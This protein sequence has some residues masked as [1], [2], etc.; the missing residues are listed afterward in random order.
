MFITLPLQRPFVG[1]SSTSPQWLQLLKFSALRL[2]LDTLWVEA[3][4]LCGPFRFVLLF[5]HSGAM[6][7][8]TLSVM[9]HG[10]LGTPR[11]RGVTFLIIGIICI[12][13][14]DHDVNHDGNVHPEGTHKSLFIHKTY[15]LFSNMGLSDHKIGVLVLLAAMCL[16]AGFTTL[17]RDLVSSTG[18]AKRFHALSS[19]LCLSLLVPILLFMKLCRCWWLN[20]QTAPVFIDPNDFGSLSGHLSAKTSLLFFLVVCI[21]IAFVVDFYST[22]LVTN[23]IGSHR[24]AHLSKVS[25]VSL[26]FLMYFLWP[27][28]LQFSTLPPST[29]SGSSHPLI[30]NHSLSVGALFATASILY[31]SN[32]LNST[33]AGQGPNVSSSGHFIGYSMAG[34]PLFAVG[35]TQMHALGVTNKL[36]SF[37]LWYHV[38]STLKGIMSDCS[39]RRIFIFLCLNLAFTFVELSYG[40]WT[41]SLGLISDGFHMLFDSAALVIGLYAAVA[42]HWKPT[43]LFSYGFHSA[44]VLSGFVNA[45]FLL[46]ISGSVFVNALARIHRPPNIRTDRLMTVSVAGLFVNLVGVVALGHAHSHG[47]GAGHGHSHVACE[48]HSHNY[49]SSSLGK[50]QQMLAEDLVHWEKR[51]AYTHPPHSDTGGDANLRGVYLHVL[52]DTLGSV[53]VIFSSYLVTTYG[54]NIA[55]PICSMF[56]ACAIGYSAAPLL[57][58]TL[59][60]L[61]LRAPA[62]DHTTTP[63]WIVQEV[64]DIDGVLAVYNPFVWSQA[65]HTTCVSLCARVDRDTCEQVILSRIQHII[66]THCKNVRHLTIQVEKEVIQHSLQA[67]S[68]KPTI[69]LHFQK[70]EHPNLHTFYAGDSGDNSGLDRRF[71]TSET[72][73]VIPI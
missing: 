55:D 15:E 5:E 24:V 16:D 61:T 36:E 25:I 22:A 20:T 71:L 67:I 8:A 69:L 18:G 56:L 42:S 45:L 57:H 1:K 9:V 68:L 38:R 40:V 62:L 29:Q 50:S 34:L 6:V 27:S 49:E 32:L 11:I 39:S 33:E 30:L 35:Q 51:D 53:G 65:F 13:I 10:S 43:R 3:L 60:I 41:N 58:D 73:T 26:S 63:E 52:A 66:S 7:L 14:F 4:R 23:R 21:G 19:M 46:V 48:N 2:C 12:T 37:G 28:G 70:C 54:W 59:R 17:S 44:E 31:A 47:D 64:L 72:A